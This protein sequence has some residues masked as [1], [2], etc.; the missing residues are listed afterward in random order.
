MIRLFMSMALARIAGVTVAFQFHRKAGNYAQ[1]A[2]A[3]ALFL[4]PAVVP[5]C[6]LEGEGPVKIAIGRIPT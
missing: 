5:I 3:T 1:S 4:A 2:C 6:Q